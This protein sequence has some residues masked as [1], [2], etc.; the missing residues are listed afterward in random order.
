MN[1]KSRI[2]L[3]GVLVAAVLLPAA[4]TQAVVRYV[5]LDGSGANGLSWATAYWSI[6]AALNDPAMTTGGEIWVKQ[7]AYQLTQAI[8]VTKP[9][10][11]LGGYSGTGD[12]RAWKTYQTTI[13]GMDKVYHCFYVTANATLDG[14]GIVYGTAGDVGGSET[15]GGGVA[16]IRC[17]ATISNCLFQY[18]YAAESGGAVATYQASNSKITNCSFIQNHAVVTGGAIY[19]E[20]STGLQI[21]DC[22]FLGNA[23]DDSGAAIHNYRCNPTIARCVFQENAASYTEVG[24]AGAILNDEAPATVKDC[25]FKGNKA[26][27]GGGVVNYNCSAVIDNCWFSSCDPATVSGGGVY[28]YGGTPTIQNCLFEQNSVQNDGG[29]I[30]DR[31]SG[32]RTIN[33]VMWQ[34]SSVGDGG[35]IYVSKSTETGALN[36]PQFINCTI[37]ANEADWLG[38]GV[39]SEDTNSSFVNC[40]IWGNSAQQ[41]SPNLGTAVSASAGKPIVRYCDIQGTTVYPGTANKNS[42]PMFVN[43]DGN[44]LSLAFDS[45][46]LDAGSNAAVLGILKDYDGANRIVDG[47]GNGTA[48]VDMGAYERQGA[49]DHLTHGQII[50]S[51]AYDNP[52]D[53]TAIHTFL[54]RLETDDT[55]TSVDFQAPS[56]ATLYT[57]PADS[58]TSSGVVETYHRSGTT[59]HVWEYWARSSD[60]SA[61]AAY[62]DGVYRIIAH[63]R[64]N[65]QGETRIG[66]LVPGTSSPVPQPNNKPQITAPALGANVPSPVVLRWAGTDPTANSVYVT[67]TDS[68]TGAEAAREVLPKTA[69]MSSEHQ[70]AEGNYEAEV[71]FANLYEIP[72]SD[73]TP[74][75]FGKTV[76]VEHQFRVLYSAVYRFW[77][78]LNHQHFYTSSVRERDKLIKNYPAIA[79]TYEGIAFYAYLTKS[80]SALSP[81]YRL[82]SGRS[83][84]Y[85]IDEQE[86]NDMLNQSPRYWMSEGIAFYAYTEGSE[87]FDSK[88]VYLFRNDI[89]GTPFFTI[90]EAEANKIITEPESAFTYIGVA[91]YAYSP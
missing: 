25:I 80:N 3:M 23:S 31:G 57:I 28:N 63:Y 76:L 35:A 26:P 10:R 5:A 52:S 82:W 81:V 30:Y 12:T 16:L 86:R 72:S 6:Q 44:D 48:L 42:N 27:Y 88:A 13:D 43:V 21:L 14:L 4:G 47:D 69:T 77:S 89:S 22:S 59:G 87:P 1:R 85:T 66:Y 17:A 40:I 56:G 79:W 8:V 67:F 29:A 75:Q 19:N 11:I 18:N 50:R 49:Q 46:C 15:L 34:N 2:S 60:P 53:T 74:F 37:V 20:E 7:G 71:A 32:G 70:L 55:L 58:H 83:H 90:S 54:L 84:F 45:P 73:G 61:L 39:Y 41:G 36:N 62:G 9:V 78:P 33:C 68:G 24:V 65:T 51:K 38:G 64:N 91:F